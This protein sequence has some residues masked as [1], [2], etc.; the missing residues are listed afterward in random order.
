M[1]NQG[2]YK[3]NIKWNEVAFQGH[4]APSRQVKTLI[5]FDIMWLHNWVMRWTSGRGRCTDG[6]HLCLCSS[7][8]PSFLSQRSE[9]SRQVTCGRNKPCVTEADVQRGWSPEVKIPYRFLVLENTHLLSEGLLCFTYQFLMRKL[10]I[11]SINRAD[12]PCISNM[13]K[14]VRL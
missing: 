9:A 6:I 13:N 1:A 11:I 14:L 4:N 8:S 7:P 2:K 3:G 10:R 5:S 12:P